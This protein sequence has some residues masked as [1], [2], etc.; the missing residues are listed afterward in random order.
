MMHLLYCVLGA[1]LVFDVLVIAMFC[2]GYFKECRRLRISDALAR[3]E[4]L[5][6]EFEV[7]ELE[8]MYQL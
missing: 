3:I 7:D 6:D 4:E 1:V 2:I 5:S 8:K